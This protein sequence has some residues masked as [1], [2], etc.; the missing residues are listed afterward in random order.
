MNGIDDPYTIDYKQD[1]MHA[2][3]TAKTSNVIDVVV[4]Q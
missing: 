3:I 2:P 4:V 1:T